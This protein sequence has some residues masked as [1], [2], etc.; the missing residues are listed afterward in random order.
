VTV[1]NPSIKY[2]LATTFINKSILMQLQKPVIH[3][4]LRRLGFNNHMPRS[5]VFASKKLGGIG[6]LDLPSEQ[7]VSQVQL[8]ISHLRATSYLKIQLLSCSN[9]TRW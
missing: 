3:A 8:L 4:V 6:L 5:I 1:F 9:L 7:G 2:L